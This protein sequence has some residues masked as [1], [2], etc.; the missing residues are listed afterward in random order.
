MRLMIK[1]LD[2]L[3]NRV[4][5]Q[6]SVKRADFLPALAIPSYLNQRVVNDLFKLNNSVILNIEYEEPVKDIFPKH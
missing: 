3:L 2:I 4:V 1:K 5:M 6:E